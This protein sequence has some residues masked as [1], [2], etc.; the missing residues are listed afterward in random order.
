MTTTPP[1]QSSPA[2]RPEALPEEVRQAIQKAVTKTLLP[3]I[4][5]QEPRYRMDGFIRWGLVE[6]EMIDGITSSV[7]ALWPAP[8]PSHGEPSALAVKAA[9]TAM[10]NWLESNA[11]ESIRG[12]E[13]AV[14]LW[15]KL[16]Q[17]AAYVAA[18][19]FSPVAGNSEDLRQAI[20]DGL[21]DSEIVESNETYSEIAT[22]ILKRI[23]AAM[24]REDKKEGV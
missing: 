24:Q 9:E 17:F 23:D 19:T 6:S 16:P 4:N 12:T 8:A 21:E 10:E 3:A 7:L 14:W 13:T 11:P 1:D 15:Q 2:P 18:R 20:E 22:N 5:G